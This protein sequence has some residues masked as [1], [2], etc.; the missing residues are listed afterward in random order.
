MSPTPKKVLTKDKVKHVGRKAH[1]TISAQSAGHD[2]VNIS[3]TFPTATL[4][5][6]LSKGSRCQ[7]TMG[8]EGAS[9]R[10]RTPT[11]SSSDPPRV[12]NI[13]KG[14]EDRYTYHE[15]MET[16]AN[17]N[18]DVLSQGKLIEKL[19]QVILSKQV[20][21][22]IL[23]IMVLKHVQK[24]KRTKFILKKRSIPHD[25]SKEGENRVESE[26]QSPKAE[27]IGLTAETSTTVVTGLSV[28]EIEIAETLLKAK[29]DTP[30]ASQ[31]AKGV[32]IKEG[33]PELKR[34]EINEA[35]LKR[36]GKAKVDESSKPPKKLKQIEIDEELAKKLQ[37][38]LQQ[39][40][41]TQKAKDRQIALDLST[42]LNE[43]YQES[44]RAATEAKKSTVKAS[45]QR[46]PS[47]NEETT[48][49]AEEK[50]EEATTKEIKYVKRLNTIAS[51]KLSKKPRVAE[52]EKETEPS[53]TS[54]AEKSS[55]SA[56][57]RSQSDIRFELYVTVTDN[58]PVKADPIS[59]QA[60]EIIHWDILEDQGK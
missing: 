8:V 16:I 9:A 45:I 53:V 33:G 41:E 3:K 7:E 24:K 29:T 5:E 40:E 1:T 44:L 46:L 60:P 57:Q 18:N 52:A 27:T 35:E 23:K 37:A 59:V 28:E 36:K 56:Q 30:K 2:S 12:V 21:I 22:S 17:I 14:G 58:D 31:K 47:K 38:E 32:E 55:Q 11:K 50:K 13:P 54:Q 26:K 25:A 39:E 34:K 51:K 6:H 4:G 42:W 10:Q 15:L 20:Q 48:P 43:E 49:K 19:Q